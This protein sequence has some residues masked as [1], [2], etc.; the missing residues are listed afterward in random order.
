MVVSAYT[1]TW[2]DYGPQII[3]HRTFKDGNWS[4]PDRVADIGLYAE[5]VDPSVAVDGKGDVHIAYTVSYRFGEPLHNRSR[6]CVKRGGRWSGP[7]SVGEDAFGAVIGN[8]STGRVCLCWREGVLGD[9]PIRV[10]IRVWD[11]VHVS[12]A[13]RIPAR[14]DGGLRLVDAGGGTFCVGWAEQSHVVLQPFTLEMIP[15]GAQ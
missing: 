8:D 12:D 15:V 6:Y 9:R 5:M 3:E 1:S 13:V 11:G 2:L 7:K 14:T 4:G 10:G